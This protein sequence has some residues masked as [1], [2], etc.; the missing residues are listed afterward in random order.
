MKIKSSNFWLPKQGNSIDE[1][2]D[3]FAP[4]AIVEEECQIFRCAVADGAAESSFAK[5]W[6]NLLVDGYCKGFNL[7][8]LQKSWREEVSRYSLAWYAEQKAESGSFAALV[9]LTLND[10]RTWAVKAIGDSCVAQIREEKLLTCLPIGEANQFD[11]NPHL[12]CSKEENNQDLKQFWLNTT[13]AWEAEDHFLLM[14]DALA[15]WFLQ[16]QEKYAD[17]PARFVSFSNQED[18]NSFVESERA[19]LDE[20]GQPNLK[21]DD[22]TLI[23]VNILE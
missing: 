1:Y 10:D 18:F 3:A 6:A 22:V 16:R 11:N 19:C 7:E 12:L 14:S 17:A 2:E 23:R 8:A 20:T 13:G 5:L 21:N 4:E 9:G 15:K